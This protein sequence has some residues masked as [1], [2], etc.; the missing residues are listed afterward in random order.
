MTPLIGTTLPELALLL[1]KAVPKLEAFRA[2]QIFDA[3]YKQGITQIKDI[4]AL[5]RPLIQELQRHYTI[6]YPVQKESLT[7]KDGTR[8]WLL[9]YENKSF[10]SVYIPEVNKKQTTGSLCISSQVGCSLQCAF[11]HTG[12]QK[13]MGNLTASQ[14]VGQ[15]MNA[16]QETKFFPYHPTKKRQVSNM[17]FMGQ[18]EPLYNFKN[19]SKA[20]MFMNDAFNLSPWKTTVSTSGLVPLMPKIGDLS[21]SLAVSLHAVTDELRDRLVPLNKQY[22]ISEVV[23]GCLL[24]L[25]QVKQHTYKRITFEYVMLDNVN[26][27]DTE[28]KELVRLLKPLSPHV[29]LIPFN[30]W[31]GTVFECSSQQRIKSFQAILQDAGIP[32][33]IRTSRGQDIMAAC[34]QLKSSSMSKRQ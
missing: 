31:P 13:F 17:V 29:N 26:D 6:G 30:P 7:S 32:C 22:P 33:H 24:Y 5:P 21:A 23:K 4:T 11:C 15:Y 10:E 18:G 34:G 3:I 27:S 1:Q 9:E 16:L 19:V 14:I 20:I 25:N 12:T 2:K 28:A 8:K